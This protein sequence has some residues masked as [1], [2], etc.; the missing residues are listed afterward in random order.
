MNDLIDVNE[1]KNKL[2]VASDKLDKGTE[3]IATKIIRSKDLDEVKDLTA[4]FNLQQTKKSVLRTMTYNQLVDSIVEQMQERVS[5]RADQFSNKEL[6][7]YLKIMNEGIEKAQQQ[8][9][10]VANTEPL[11]QFNQ[12]NNTV[13]VNQADQLDAASR[14]RVSRALSSILAKMK[15]PPMLEVVEENVSESD[16]IIES[17]PVYDNVEVSEVPIKIKLN[18]EEN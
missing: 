14:Q 8:I 11:I 7:D 6:L 3:K 2:Q 17:E 9:S 18:E 10:T 15:N 1:E 5:K 12:Q 4:L 13:V 16:E